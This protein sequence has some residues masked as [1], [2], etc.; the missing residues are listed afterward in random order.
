M[1]KVK[2]R[3]ALMLFTAI[4]LGVACKQLDDAVECLSNPDCGANG[5]CNNGDCEGGYPST[6]DS[7]M[8]SESSPA[9]EDSDT[10]DCVT[11]PA[12]VPQAAQD[13]E[14]EE[15]CVDPG[16][17]QDCWL[18]DATQDGV[19]CTD[20]TECLSGQ[21]DTDRGVCTCSSRDDCNDGADR[22]G[23]C[24]VDDGYCGPSSCNGYLVC[25]CF[26][27]CIEGP[28]PELQDSERCCEGDYSLDPL[29]R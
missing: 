17:L 1:Y 27:G 26:G 20:N 24:N 2:T 19:A 14:N 3:T 12:P 18:M 10:R 21:C 25:A 28:A 9:E 13:T 29:D 23:T 5:V 4:L 15:C 16:S 7:S 22:Q 11:V 6:D 8:D